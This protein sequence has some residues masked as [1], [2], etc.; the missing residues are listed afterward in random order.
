V[1]AG[2]IVA[3]GGAALPPEGPNPPLVEYLLSLARRDRP[4]VCLIATAGGDA[5]A[6]ALR[7]Y[8]AFAAY[9]CRPSELKLF[10]R[11][12]AD[13]RS[14]VLDQD[15]IYVGGGSTANLLAVWRVHGLDA[16]LAEA[17]REGT[18]LS[19]V[20][21]G[22]NCWFEASVTD[23]FDTASLAGLSDG[24][25][26]LAGSCCPHSDG[27]EQ[28][29]PTYHRLVGSGELPAG[30]AADDGAA[31]VFDG[32]ELREVVSWRPD[33][34][35]YRVERGPDGVDERPLEARRLG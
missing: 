10:P 32:S 3:I 27:E 35:A 25:G 7:F 12:V 30:V 21:A 15:V 1:A 26:L 33:A 29:R 2:P 13:L 17:H 6:S 31:L 19:G 18:V 20:S 16:I 23:S 5:E 11:S 8:R 34:R 14:F 4:R 24:L 9:D 22:M 28:R